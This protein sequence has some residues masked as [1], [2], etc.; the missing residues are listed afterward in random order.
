M[1]LRPKK[2]LSYKNLLIANAFVVLLKIIYLT[3]FQKQFTGV[4]DFTIAGNIV[5]YN[6]YSEFIQQG[7][8][9]FKLPVYPY[10]ISFF[11]LIFGSE[12]LFFLAIFQ[13]ILSFLTP[14]LI[15]HILK[16]VG[17]PMI[18]II[19]GLL[20]L[21][22]P[23]YFLYPGI[24]EATNIFIT[25]LLLWFYQYLRI[26][27]QKSTGIFDFAVL[28]FTTAALFLTQ[29]VVV[30]LC[31]LMIFSLLIYKKSSVKN[32]LVLL[33]TVSI[34]YSPWIIRNYIVFDQII[35]SKTP[36]WQNIYYGFTPNGQLRDDLKLIPM[37][38]DIYL[39]EQRDDVTELVMEDIYR[40]EVS[41]VTNDDPAIF[42]KKAASN[43]LCLWFV[44]PK[45][46]DDNS[47]SVLIG[48]KLYVIILNLT[49]LL[50]LIFLYRRSQML[51][52]FSLLFF[53]NFTFPY[54]IGHAANMRFKL[55][56]EWYQ[57][58]LAAF[59]IKEISERFFIK[60]SASH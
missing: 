48:R 19:A 23:A 10:T 7:S 15:F 38:R 55:D 20:F 33:L 11:I 42:I 45:Y 53:G 8:T 37:K 3:F 29:V 49:T 2:L 18:G 58:I 39:N 32:W 6:L 52:W 51:F 44:P 13:A 12:S 40:K 43:F 28:G 25:I 27:F 41:R 22:S 1:N 16:T 31:C 60:K 35:M 26:W 21:C 59:T 24:I 17:S 5:K 14:V 4:E 56:F 30:P 50:S 57:L 34:L 54:L 46:F 9:A 36:V 47:I